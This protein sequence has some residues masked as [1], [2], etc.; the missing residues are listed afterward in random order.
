MLINGHPHRHTCP[1]GM[2]GSSKIYGLIVVSAV[3]LVSG[4]TGS[5][6]TGPGGSGSDDRVG[7]QRILDADLVYSAG[8]GS[9][10]LTWTA[11]GDD[12][13]DVVDHYEIRYSYSSPF[14][15]EMSPPVSDPPTPSGRGTQQSYLFS[16]PLRGR[17]LY[18]SIRSYD[19]SGNAS[20]PSEAA[21]VHIEGFSVDGV[22]RDALSGR[23]L[24]G[25]VIEITERLVHRLAT[26]A[27]GRYTMGDV[28][29]GVTNVS[30]RS[31]T[32]TSIFH[33]YDLAVDLDR[34]VSLEHIM[35]ENQPAENQ[36][37]DNILTLMLMAA[38][39]HSGDS[40]LRKW[41]SYPVPVYV[42]P[43][44]NTYGI[45]YEDYCKRAVQ[46]WNDRTGLD[47]FT[48]VDAPPDD[49]TTVSF[50]P[51]SEMAPNNGLT[52]F[53]EDG[54][55][56]PIRASISII[57]DF[58]DAQELWTVA[59]HELGHAIRLQHLP[60]GYL[61]YQGR[62]LPDSPTSDEIKMVQLYLALPN[63]FDMTPYDPA[64]PR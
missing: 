25:M 21:W 60:K 40:R 62:P 5:D 27:E 37:V 59:L 12:F 55:R 47:I 20:V 54:A 3:V 48:L 23:T 38:G 35:I 6:T 14:D 30:I 24:S 43:F 7:P 46:H 45:D 53:E 64:D 2:F 28:G 51:R 57:D 49:G 34:D 29:A 11:P 41:W 39:V 52:G 42:P 16:D 33:N 61:M 22:C 32:G 8:A 18:A 15:W 9:A 31:G 10:E 44:V 4:C 58:Q 50:R 13:D 19:A 1:S 36:A 17:D 26:D 63:D 56:F